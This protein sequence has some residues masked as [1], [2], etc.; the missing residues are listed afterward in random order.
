MT[1][2]S[3]SILFFG[4]SD[5]AVP[6]LQKL[7]DNN[8][9][10]A[11]IITR[12]DKPVGRKQI[13]TPPPIKELAIKYNLPVIQPENLLPL[14]F[15]Y[16]RRSHSLTFNL[17][18]TA[19][20]GKII[21]Q[22]ILD[23][24]EFGALNVHPSLL[25]KYR[26]PAP[27]QA[28]ILNGDKE[29]GV[30]IMLM[31]KKMDHGPILAQE[32]F[33]ITTIFPAEKPAFTD[34]H[35]KLADIGADL[36]IKTIPRF[37]AGEIIPIPQDDSL[38]TYTG[39]ITKDDGKI[40]WNKSALEIERQIRAFT[41]W[42]GCWTMFN[43][44]RLKIIN[45]IAGENCPVPMVLSGEIFKLEKNKM[46]VKCGQEFLEILELQVEGKKPTTGEAFLSGYPLM[47]GGKLV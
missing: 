44:K 8:Y 29:A 22:E 12:P 2:R 30:T 33:S 23:I 43:G 26:G 38:A 3:I 20:Y 32:K 5:F 47:I 46:A 42:P 13:P 6:T 11:A 17:I 36:L 7:V 9:S 25:P 10:I 34:F 45:A 4:T 40:D 18:I 24:A 31:D 35:D 19:S 41:P 39:I 21:P 1:S 15:E 14:D 16:I 27:L 28:T 37:I